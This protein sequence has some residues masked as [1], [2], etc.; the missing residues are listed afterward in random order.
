V[1]AVSPDP[2]I[3]G[4][5]NAF[6]V[7]NGTPLTDSWLAFSL[8]GPGSTPFPSMNLTLALDKP[9]L[10]IGPNLTD[11]DGKLVWNMFVTNSLQGRGVWMQVVQFGRVTDVV[12]TTVQ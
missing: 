1:F 3:A 4:Q 5:H 2:L 7:T 11:P 8:V 10:G 6:D 12:D 9:K